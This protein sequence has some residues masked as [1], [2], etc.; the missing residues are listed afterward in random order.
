[1]P[2]E[3]TEAPE[4]VETPPATPEV[5]DEAPETGEPTWALQQDEWN[6][7][8]GF[9]NAA[10]PVLQHVAQLLQDGQSLT[11]QPQEPEAPAQLPDIDP[12]EPTSVQRYVDAL[13]EQRV[14]AAIQNSLGPYESVLG[15][16]ASREGEDLAK[17]EFEKIASE[18]GEFDQ[19]AAFAMASGLIDRGM[20]PGQAI[21]EA[22][23]YAREWEKRIATKAVEDYKASLQTI[24]SAP[25]E[26]TGGAAATEV[27]GVPTGR[28]RYEVAINRALARR[29]P[30]TPIG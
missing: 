15:M 27:E 23:T 8:N 2:D 7:V 5:V 30:I 6:R 26:Q 18:V 3:V 21:R 17:R 16:V 10:A 24:G 29:N 11:P 9:I 22:G 20:E 25:Q 1:M 4:V 19:E 28:G 13:L 12:F 14:A